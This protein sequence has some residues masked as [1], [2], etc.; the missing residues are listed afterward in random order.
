MWRGWIRRERNRESVRVRKREREN[1]RIYFGL[2]R[3]K[4]KRIITNG[5][6]TLAV[7]VDDALEHEGEHER[8]RLSF[9]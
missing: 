2:V 1:L 7:R 4:E 9:S 3:E 8:A 5:Y 6:N